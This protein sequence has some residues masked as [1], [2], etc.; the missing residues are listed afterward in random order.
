MISITHRPQVAARSEH[1]I[2]LSKKV[3]EGRTYA[4]IKELGLDEKIRQVAY[5]ISG[6]DITQKQLDYATEM[7]MS[8]S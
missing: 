7:V 2:L 4:E 5:L 8:H 6:G 1:Q 3:K